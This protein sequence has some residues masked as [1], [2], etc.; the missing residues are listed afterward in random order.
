MHQAIS[1]AIGL[2]PIFNMM[3][4]HPDV[5]PLQE[6]ACRCLSYLAVSGKLLNN[7]YNL[8]IMYIIKTDCEKMHHL[9]YIYIYR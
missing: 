3:L 8:L 4:A 7:S 9:F 1:K 5:A 2:R 6:E